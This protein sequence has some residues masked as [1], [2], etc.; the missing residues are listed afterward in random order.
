MN[1]VV[2]V[3]IISY[4][5]SRKKK[6]TYKQQG[7]QQW[8]IEEEEYYKST[9]YLTT[10]NKYNDVLYDKGVHGEYKIH[11]GRAIRTVSDLSTKTPNSISHEN[12]VLIYDKFFP[13]TQVS[14]SIKQQHI[15]NINEKIKM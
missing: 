15:R 3:S 11:L 7:K 1:I 5:R 8:K 4:I 6:E 12:P 10:K 9:Y 2:F 14:E 13:Y